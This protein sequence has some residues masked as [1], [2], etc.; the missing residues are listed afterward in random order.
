MNV[1]PLFRRS[2]GVVLATLL[3]S[4]VAAAT[5]DESGSSEPGEQAAS[6]GHVEQAEALGDGAVS[7]A[8]S[9]QSQTP[10]YR[11]PALGKPRVRIAGGVRGTAPN[12]PT[13]RALVPDHTGHTVSDQPSL[14][15][16]LDGVP[17]TGSVLVFTLVDESQIEPLIEVELESPEGAGIQRIDLAAYEV[18]LRPGTEYEWSVGLIVDPDERSKDPVCVGWIDRVERPEGLAKS[19]ATPRA[20]AENGLW[21]DAL[22][23]TEDGASRT[24]LLRQVGLELPVSPGG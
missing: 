3:C 19:G 1:A 15:W 12:L 22:A 8:G 13:L 21:Y 14:F 4:L 2:R 20:Y 18:R 24:A 10:V 9:A 23:A 11:P 5:A 7:A 6:A 17:P 16:H